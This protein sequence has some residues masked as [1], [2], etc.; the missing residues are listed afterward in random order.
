[1]PVEAAVAVLQGSHRLLVATEA[2]VVAERAAMVERQIAHL[3]S[4]IRAEAAAEAHLR[5]A[6]QVDNRVVQVLL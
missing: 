4:Q 1:M 6:M 5:T 2:S 3:V